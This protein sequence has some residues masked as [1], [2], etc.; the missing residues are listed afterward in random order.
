MMQQSAKTTGDEKFLKDWNRSGG[1]GGKIH[2]VFLTS[3]ENDQS[4][5]ERVRTAR[6]RSENQKPDNPK[7]FLS[8]F[9]EMKKR[10]SL[11]SAYTN[12]HEH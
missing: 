1:C 5:I 8:S 11:Y 7:E 2:P 4:S 12:S 6:L 9:R 3:S 10:I